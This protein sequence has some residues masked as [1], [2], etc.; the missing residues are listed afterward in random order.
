MLLLHYKMS[1]RLPTTRW[2][3]L[4]S[5]LSSLPATSTALLL[6]LLLTL[7]LML[8]ALLLLLLLLLY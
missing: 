4:K 5:L 7:P 6:M 8:L 1:S 2:M 3:A